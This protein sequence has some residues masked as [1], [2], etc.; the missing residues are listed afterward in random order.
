MLFGARITE[1]VAGRTYL[2]F[3]EQGLA[4]PGRIVGV[5]FSELVE[6]MAEGGYVR[7]NWITSRKVQQA[8]AKLLR[9]YGGDLNSLHAACP[10]RARPRG[11]Y[12]GLQTCQAD[13]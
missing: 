8:A 13:D 10:R 1:S 2:P 4:T 6:I 11:P 9:D 7:Y 12:A 5:G 3:L